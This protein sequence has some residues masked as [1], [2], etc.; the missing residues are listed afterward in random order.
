MPSEKGAAEPNTQAELWFKKLNR[1]VPRETI[2]SAPTNASELNGMFHVEHSLFVQKAEELAI[3]C[4]NPPISPE[5]PLFH[6]KHLA[7]QTSLW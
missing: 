7:S 3:L 6:V 5:P 2:R 1:N 4:H